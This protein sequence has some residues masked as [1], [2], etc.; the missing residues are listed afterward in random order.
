M[1]MTSK[2]EAVAVGSI[3]EL[4][5]KKSVVVEAPTTTANSLS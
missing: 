5:K 4:P 2:W 3:P 1:S